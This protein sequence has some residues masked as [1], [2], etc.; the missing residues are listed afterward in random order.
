MLKYFER[1]KPGIS[2]EGAKTTVAEQPQS[3]IL[4]DED[5]KFLQSLTEEEAP[6][7]PER[8]IVILDN[9]EKK[10][11]KDAQEAIMNGANTIPLPTSPPAQAETEGTETKEGKPSNLKKAQDYLG[12]A[13]TGLT[14]R[15]SNKVGQP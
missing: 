8:R 2:K 14:Q 11:G 6:P 10:T 15:F 9:G 13:R 5:E 3:P 4:N 12:Y 7:L 1:S